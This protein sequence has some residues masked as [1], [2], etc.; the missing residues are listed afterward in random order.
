MIFATIIQI[1]ILSMNSYKKKQADMTF[2]EVSKRILDVFIA[3]IAIIFTSPLMLIIVIAIKLDSQ[4]PVL[5]DMP[6]RVGRY[7]KAF[8][9]YKFRSM[10][11]NAHQMLRTDPEFAALYEEYKANSYK[12]L[13]DPRV[14]RVGRILRKTSMDELPQFF[15][16]LKGEM[17]FVGPRAYFQDELNEQA[18]H[19]PKTRK[20]IQK[21]LT[22]KPGLTGPWQVGGRSEVSFSRRIEM[23]ATY[24]K[25]KSLLYD[26]WIILKTPYA[27][28]FGKGAY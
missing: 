4:G 20:L 13:K 14:T 2:Y 7:G 9:M 21:T 18:A 15:N 11:P 28:L 8:H 23:D 25:R 1:L 6:K 16:I 24:A 27:V 22:A 12:I 17:S 10:I 3:S 5:A 26:F 19:Y